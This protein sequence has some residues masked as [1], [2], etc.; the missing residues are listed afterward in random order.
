MDLI[1]FALLGAACLVCSLG[2]V[3]LIGWIADRR[4]AAL[5]RQIQAEALIALGHMEMQRIYAREREVFNDSF[6]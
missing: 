3:E 4:D 2:W 5:I 6:D 1:A